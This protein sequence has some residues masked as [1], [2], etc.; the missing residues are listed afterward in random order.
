MKEAD[1]KEA[2]FEKLFRRIRISRFNEK[3]ER[4]SVVRSPTVVCRTFTMDI[5]GMRA[6]ERWMTLVD[7][8]RI[9]RPNPKRSCHFVL[10]EAR[11]K[12]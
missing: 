3:R 12:D 9:R 2:T 7:R 10:A 5:I 6:A 1:L 11:R 4:R 8:I